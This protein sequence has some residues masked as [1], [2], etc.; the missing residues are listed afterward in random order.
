MFCKLFIVLFVCSFLTIVG[1]AG[2][3]NKVQ[4]LNKQQQTAKIES[5]AS[6]YG[7]V[8][9]GA[10]MLVADF[11]LQVLIHEGTHVL[12]LVSLDNNYKLTGFYPYPSYYSD[13]RGFS[14]AYITGYSTGVLNPSTMALVSIA[15]KIVDVGILYSYAL[16][17]EF[18]VLPSNQYAQLAMWTIAF[19]AWVDLAKD[20]C[21]GI[22][23]NGS[24]NNDVV[25]FEEY[26]GYTSP[27]EKFAVRGT[28]VLLASLSVYPL[29]NGLRKVIDPSLVE[30][31]ESDNGLVIGLGMVG[32]KLEF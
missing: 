18:D 17:E 20:F 1:C 32:Y 30:D 16:L 6:V 8:G 4:I 23:Y 19:G 11:F 12:V 24:P 27:W 10:G 14:F 22:C 21:S 25:K 13:E 5:P 2:S 7:L 26:M 9:A 15:P 28:I 3:N 29:Y 31:P